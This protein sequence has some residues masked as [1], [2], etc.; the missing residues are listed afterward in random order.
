MEA[1]PHVDQLR[2]LVVGFK[3]HV[4]RPLRRRLLGLVGGGDG[5]GNSSTSGGGGGVGG[6]GGAGVGLAMLRATGR[7]R[8][9]GVGGLSP[10]SGAFKAALAGREALLEGGEEEVAL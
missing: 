6:S 1:V 4:Y 9:V 5:Q 7:G 8:G 3:E 2:G 10:H